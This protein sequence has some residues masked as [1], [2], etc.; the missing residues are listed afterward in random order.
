MI[1]KPV[2]LIICDG[3]G[4]SKNKQSNPI[5]IAQKPTFDYIAKYFP[6]AALQA[7]GPVVGVPWGTS[8]NSE[9]GHIAIGSGKFVAQEI[10]RINNSIESGNFFRLKM[11]DDVISTAQKNNS[12]IH[13]LGLISAGGVHAHIEHLMALLDLLA[14]RNIKNKV[15]LHLITDGR[16]SPPKEGLNFLKK[17]EAKIK[18]AG[19][20]QIA[21]LG[22]RY[23][24]MDRNNNWDRVKKYYD[25]LTGRAEIGF[26]TPEGALE[27]YYAENINDEFI[28]PLAI[29]DD[30]SQPIAKIKDGDIV[31]FFN[32]R[33]DRARQLSQV[34]LDQNFRKALKS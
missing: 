12:D 29:V 17:I 16:D 21:T 19:L 13:L 14:K 33:A 31:I 1:F 8:G 34:F 11:W 2:I 10:T 22:G 26:K 18:E 6:G 9:V 27:H 7:S 23:Y 20:G 30:Q 25:A 28:P 4:L 5:T 15:F 24:G 32:F 3:L